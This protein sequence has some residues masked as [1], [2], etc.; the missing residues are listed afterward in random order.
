[1]R[2]L[3]KFLLNPNTIIVLDIDGVLAEYQFN[4]Y[5]VAIHMC[6]Q[7]WETFV[8]QQK[9]YTTIIKPIPRL[10]QLVKAKE[11]KN[12]YVLSV[13]EEY[14]KADKT[15]FCKKHYKLN[16]NQIIFVSKRKDKLTKLEQ[17]QNKIPEKQIV[18]IDD[19]VETL[20]YIHKTNPN[21]YTLHV[22]SLFT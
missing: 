14:E 1:M 8:K 11:K 20:N 18:M 9:P 12:T 5:H 10:Q 15:E 19:T 22:S 7:D 21:I 6:D 16:T 17:I 13:A 2:S 4:T 3:E